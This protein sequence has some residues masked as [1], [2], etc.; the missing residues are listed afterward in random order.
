MPVDGRRTLYGGTNLLFFTK[1]GPTERI[2]YYDLSNIEVGKKSPLTVA[3]FEDSEEIL[4]II[5]AKQ[6]EISEAI[7]KL[8]A[9]Q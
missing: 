7:A 5:E 6:K 9:L 2:G 3:H 1:G 8:R 4:D